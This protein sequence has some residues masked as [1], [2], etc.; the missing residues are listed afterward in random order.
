MAH[1][2]RKCLEWNL[3]VPIVVLHVPI[4]VLHVPIVVLHVPIVVLHGV[5]RYTMVLQ[6][7]YFLHVCMI[8]GYV[9]AICV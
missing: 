4:V 7:Y 2:K 5:N 6:F 8:L 9:G 3:H 1:T